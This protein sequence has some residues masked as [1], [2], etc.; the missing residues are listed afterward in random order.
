[1]PRKPAA[2]QPAKTQEIVTDPALLHPTVR[3]MLE[4]A[5]RLFAELGVESVTLNRIVEESGQ[6]NRSA[7]HYHFG[8][9]GDIVNQL[10]T[11]RF[12]HVNVLR[13]RALDALEASGKAGDLHAVVLAATEPLAHAVRYEAWGAHFLRIQAQTI[14]SPSLRTPEVIDPAVLS[15]F[16]RTQEMA[17]KILP[18]IS[19]SAMEARFRLVRDNVVFGLV[20]IVR[21]YGTAGITPAVLDNLATFCANG[22]AMPQGAVRKAT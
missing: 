14:L 3:L 8:S 1:M 6:R 18:N 22:L 16:L 11:M 20:A 5:E 21:E 17:R 4:V 9:R 15:G 19:A 12:A 10:L 7:L 2:S 13:N